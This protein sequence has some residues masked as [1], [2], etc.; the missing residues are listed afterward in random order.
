[1]NAMDNMDYG[2]LDKQLPDSSIKSTPLRKKTG[3]DFC[4]S[5]HT[6]SFAGGR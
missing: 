4:S 5:A 1:M 2:N 6:I 3:A